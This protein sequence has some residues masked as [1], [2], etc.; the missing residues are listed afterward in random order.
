MGGR[1]WVIV[2][3]ALAVSLVLWVRAIYSDSATYDETSHVVSGMSYWKTGDFR[4]A[5]DHPPLA[6]LWFSLPPACMDV[7]WPSP[8]DPLWIDANVMHFGRRVLFE[9]GNDGDGLVRAARWMMLPIFLGVLVSVFI[10]TRR[11]FGLAAAMVALALAGLSPE[12][13][14]H[15][16]LA[17]TDAPITL[18]MFL[19]LLAVD[20]ALRK[21]TWVPIAAAALV[22]SLAIATKL[23]WPLVVP[24]LALMVSFHCF[25]RRTRAGNAS[26]APD[27]LRRRRTSP[28]VIAVALF[29]LLPPAVLWSSYFGRSSTIA[30]VSAPGADVRAAQARAAATIDAMW[31]RSMRSSGRGESSPSGGLIEFAYARSL[32]PEPYLLGIAMTQQVTGGRAA[33]LLGMHSQRGWW[34]Y[35]PAAFICKTPIPTMILLALGLTAVVRRWKELSR[36]GTLLVGLL[37]FI[38]LYTALI[39]GSNFN[40]GH[41]HMLPIYPAIYAI[42][43]AAVLLATN[44]V[45][46]AVVGGCVL[47]LLIGALLHSGGELGFFNEFAGGPRNGFR[48]LADSNIDWGQDLKRLAAWQRRHANEPIKLGYFGTALPQAYLRDA[49]ALPSN[50]E[51]GPPAELSEGTYVVSATQLLGVYDPLLR[52]AN[53]DENALADMRRLAT[54]GSADFDRLRRAMFLAR[55]AQRPADE[56]VGTSLFVYRLTRAD[57]A[58]LATP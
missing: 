34:Y 40:I 5:P 36:G 7:H 18:L 4:L 30:E 16:H 28:F 57:A 44:R 24:A 10:A 21:A 48:I 27:G 58:A 31:T 12:W 41:R 3:G 38:V 14:A 47:W 9:S 45:M 11:L 42:C 20:A 32:A 6:K 39:M 8:T 55:L 19:V 49:T 25:A 37:S 29:V 53:W 51:F 17:T 15:A 43:G 56:R 26:A 23:S 52:A 35:F 46:R 2:G 1:A 33:Y 13:L 22:F 54:S 50:L